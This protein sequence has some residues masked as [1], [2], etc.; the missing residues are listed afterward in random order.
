MLLLLEMEMAVG[1]LALVL[2]QSQ[3]R[4]SR[5]I[6]ILDDA[7]LVERRKE[8]SW[9]FLRPTQ[10]RVL[11]H[12]R[13]ILRDDPEINAELYQNDR[14]RLETVR[15]T[16][17]EM[18]DRYF[19]AHA[20]EWDAIR[21]LHI[22]DDQVESAMLALLAQRKLGHLL[23]IGTG[24]GRMVEIFGANADRI[25]AIDKNPEMLRL[26]RAKLANGKDQGNNNLIG[27]TE[28]ALGDFNSLQIPRGSVDTVI[29]HHVLHFAQQPELVISEIARVMA[30]SGLLL[31]VDFAQ[32]NRE[33]LR[34]EHAHA[35]LGFSTDNITRWFADNQIEMQQSKT[36]KGGP[37]D[38]KIWL[39][40]KYAIPN[41]ASTDVDTLP[42]RA[43][44]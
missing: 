15:M 33:E 28:L 27:K 36:L 8:G 19:E 3:P 26:A 38:I 44:I 25:T 13:R 18:A 43:L 41:I 37:L 5:H 17:A 2:E 39:G 35:R 21:S 40:R 42:K 11:P 22:A 6:R 10:H 14:G 9:V 7:G 32:H 30:R 23:D 16:R 29:L 12:V 34:T 4:I 24:T 1:E 20:R 31:I